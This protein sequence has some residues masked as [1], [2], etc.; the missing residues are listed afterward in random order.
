MYN[1]NESE[2][3]IKYNQ[4]LFK[5]CY[6]LATKSPDPSTQNGAVLV[7]LRNIVGYGWNDFPQGVD[8]Q[9]WHGDKIDKYARVVHA[10]VAAILSAARQGY[11]TIGTTLICPWA[12]CSNCAKH[13]AAAGISKLIRHSFAN[14]G[15]STGSHW[16]AECQL[17]DE[18]MQQAGVEIFEVE[19]LTTNIQLRRDGI[20]W[21]KEAAVS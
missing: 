15:T 13:I 20:L 14:S 11:S 3:S 10:E 12:A 1:S 9:Y 16:F 4:G 8:T 2:A 6:Q 19:P 7:H 17:G 5:T 18:I 21:P